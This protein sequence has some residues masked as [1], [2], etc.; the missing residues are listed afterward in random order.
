MIFSQISDEYLLT[1]AIFFALCLFFL[2]ARHL[3]CQR[4]KNDP[5]RRFALDSLKMAVAQKEM[6][7][8]KVQAGDGEKDMKAR[9]LGLDR[10]GLELQTQDE[11]PQN[12]V[13]RPIEANFTVATADGPK[14]YKFDSK[15]VKAGG[16]PPEFRLFL[17][18]PSFLQVEKKRHFVRIRPDLDSVKKNRRLAA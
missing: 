10:R 16:T 18:V 5:R 6:F 4:A 7:Y 12:L 2:V 13:S 11:I 9:L 17:Q 8:L 3:I 1:T 15:I 14:F